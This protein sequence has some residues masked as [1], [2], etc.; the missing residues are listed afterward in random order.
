M[1]KDTLAMLAYLYSLPV[2]HDATLAVYAPEHNLAAKLA[3]V[4]IPVESLK[5]LIFQFITSAYMTCHPVSLTTEKESF[6]SM[7]C[8]SKG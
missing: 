1:V 7:L 4:D 8:L 5:Q 3:L 2:V 6:N